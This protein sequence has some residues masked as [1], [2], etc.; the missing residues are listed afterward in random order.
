MK[1]VLMSTREK[2]GGFTLIELLIVIAIIG[3]LSTVVLVGLSG[4]RQSGRDARRLS[5]LQQ[6]RVLLEQYANACA[7]NYP[8]V[9]PVNS[10]NCSD[11]SAG[12]LPFPVSPQTGVWKSAFKDKFVTKGLIETIES[13]F[14]QDPLA[15][16]AIEGGENHPRTYQYGVDPAT[17]GAYMLAAGLEDASNPA[18]LDDNDESNIFSVDCTDPVYCV[19]F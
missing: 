18:L 5:D 1:F 19:G 4:F 6:L 8:M 17:G 3:L 13:P 12:G 2:R 16:G 15:R 10:N 11:V 9:G 7:G 14:P